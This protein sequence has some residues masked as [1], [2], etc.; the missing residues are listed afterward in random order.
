M[1]PVLEYSG[2]LADNI[3]QCAEHL[4]SRNCFCHIRITQSMLSDH[5]RRIA[6]YY[7]KRSC[8]KN[9][10]SLLNISAYNINC[11]FQTIVRNTACGH[12]CTFFLYLQSCEMFSLASAFEQDRNDPCAGSHIQDPCILSDLCKAG[13]KNRIHSEAELLWILNY[14]KSIL[15]VIDPLS[16]MYQISLRISFHEIFYLLLC[17]R[18]FP[19][20]S[21]PS[22][23]L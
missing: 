13:Q 5:I 15:Q 17:L 19:V 22:R 20:P 6:C 10:S 9:P 7:I 12:I 14:I 4:M 21:F 11:R 1:S 8:S 2:R 18:V 23:K 16:R 3:L